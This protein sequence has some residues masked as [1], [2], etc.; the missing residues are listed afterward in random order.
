MPMVEGRFVDGG[1]ILPSPFVVRVAAL[2]FPLLRQP[3]MKSL[4]AINV[5]PDVFVAFLAE[6]SLCRFIK[7]LVALCAVV[8]PFRMP[9]D[10]L[11]RHQGRFKTVSPCVPYVPSAD[12]GNTDD[13]MTED[14]DRFNSW[15]RW[16]RNEGVYMY[17]CGGDEKPG[18]RQHAVL[19]LLAT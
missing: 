9:L 17:R 6:S 13:E 2:T 10:D 4:L 8:F 11:A 12:E 7:P 5:L 16:M 18:R 1:D 19:Q 3:A 14:G 15:K